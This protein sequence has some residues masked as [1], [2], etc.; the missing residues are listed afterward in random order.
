MHG[1]PAKTRW[2]QLFTSNREHTDEWMEESV[3]PV[4][5]KHN[6]H[7]FNMQIHGPRAVALCEA[8][9]TW[10]LWAVWL[11][12]RPLLTWA[13]QITQRAIAR[14]GL[15]QTTKSGEHWW[16][17][18]RLIFR[19]FMMIM[20]I[21]ICGI[22]SWQFAASDGSRGRFEDLWSPS[23]CSSCI[24]STGNNCSQGRNG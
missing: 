1:S 19:L 2:L 8:L 12:E 6:R 11:S 22:D 10:E 24:E 18:P 23:W 3:L 4:L 20:M 13:T 9:V 14:A 15:V 21:H 17:V 5:V 7:V 16:E